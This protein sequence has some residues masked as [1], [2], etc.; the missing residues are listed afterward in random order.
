MLC[1]ARRPQLTE[2]LKAQEGLRLVRY[3]DSK[4]IWTIG[5]GHNMEAK[6]LLWLMPGMSIT[7]QMADV[8]LDHD[9]DDT[10]LALDHFMAWWRDLDDVR[11]QVI[12]DM[13]FNMGVDADPRGGLD[14]FVNTLLAVKEHRWQEARDGMLASK[15]HRD[16][17]ARAEELAQMMLT[18]RAA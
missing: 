4:G 6:P 17:G 18:G 15:W 5:Y 7:K 12:A 10:L 8:I 2:A 1:M 3:K 13:A 14:S 9:I 16:V 11:E